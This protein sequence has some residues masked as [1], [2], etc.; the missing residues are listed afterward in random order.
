MSND[1]EVVENE[2]AEALTKEVVKPKEAKPKAKLNHKVKAIRISGIRGGHIMFKGIV[3]GETFLRLI[4][5]G[6]WNRESKQEFDEMKFLGYERPS[7]A[8]Q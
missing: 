7:S 6:D 3:G 4:P 1:R 5:V 8:R 2:V